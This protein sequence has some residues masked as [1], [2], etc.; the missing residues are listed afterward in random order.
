MKV[1]TQM[2]LNEALKFVEEGRAK[3]PQ[4]WCVHLHYIV[5]PK[6]PY[7]FRRD[8][9]EGLPIAHI[10][11]AD[12][13]TLT[14]LARMNGVRRVVLEREG[15]KRQHIDMCGA[16]LKSLLLNLGVDIEDYR[17]QEGSDSAN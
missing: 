3:D 4:I 6:S 5:F 1:F 9:K 16:P 15:T 13:E 14:K 12:A 10:F 2:E 7:C 17:V 11:G 8:V